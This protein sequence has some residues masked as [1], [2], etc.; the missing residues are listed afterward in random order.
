MYITTAVILAVIGI[1]LLA[2]ISNGV[3]AATGLVVAVLVAIII[4]KRNNEI[5]QKTKNNRSG[6]KI[7]TNVD[8]GGV[9]RLANIDGY[10]EDLE[11][12]VIR[13]HLYR[14]GDY[15]WYESLG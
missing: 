13:K 12:K 8:V 14:E 5:S 11:L 9:F 10:D 3:A 2:N 1:I 15:F 7:I 6:L 4:L